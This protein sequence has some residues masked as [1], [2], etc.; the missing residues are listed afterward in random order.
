[1]ARYMRYIPVKLGIM[2]ARLLP[3]PTRSIFLFG[4][5]GTGK[6]TWIRERFPNA[7]TY[8]LLDTGEALRLSKTPGAL[9]HE[10]VERPQGSWAV[11][12]EVQK[13]PELLNEV[14]RLIEGRG[15]RFVLSGSSARKLRR[16][17]VNLLAGRAVTS[18]L[19]PLVSAELDFEFYVEHALS[20]GM[21]PMAV[22]DGD[23]EDY[24]RAYAETYL[25]QEVQAEAFTRNVGAFARFLEI[26]ARQNAQATNATSI[27]RD[28]GIDRRTVQSHFAILNDT[29]IGFW[30]PAWKLKA[31]TKQVRQSKFY[32]FDCGVARALSGRLPYPPS[33]EETGPLLE[34]FILN[35]I[36]AFL[37]YSGRHYRPCYWR[38]YDNAEVD[39]LCETAAG[40][41]AIEIKAARRWDRRFNRGLQ[42]VRA[43]L[44]ERAPTCYGVYLGPR[45]ARW[46]DVQ[47]LPA[48]DFL[49]RL[50]NGDVLR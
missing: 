28:A 21:L 3:T 33:Q 13:V 5:R 19:F 2:Y 12:D 6:T 16:R 31:A 46:D 1:M 14:H 40:F 15:L 35:E 30:L 49:K 20:Y 9:Y 48:L 7:A 32:F 47:V 25:V 39:V 42:R 37:S 44:G 8:D 50:W 23:P 36:R 29:L 4:P 24:L 43:Y 11:I 10:L 38:S 17:G 22:T 26:A 34:T 18:N 27:A 45:P 41:A